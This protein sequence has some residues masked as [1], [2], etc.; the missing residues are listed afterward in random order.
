VRPICRT[1]NG[2]ETSEQSNG[3]SKR[4]PFNERS[5][6]LTI[7]GVTSSC[8]IKPANNSESAGEN[9]A[10]GRNRERIVLM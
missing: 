4:K 9:E 2:S 3:Y 8:A 7:T 1:K 5:Q 10:V 6:K